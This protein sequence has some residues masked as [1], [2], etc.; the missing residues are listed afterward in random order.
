M[1]KILLIVLLLA[2][3][4]VGRLLA[5]VTLQVVSKNV[6]KT[7]PWKPGME[8]IVNGEKADVTVVPT[9][10]ATISVAAELSAKH[11]SLDTA[12]ADV[13]TWQLVVNT[14]GKKV[15]IRAYV[16]VQ[17]GKRAPVSNMRAQIKIR[18][19]RQCAV[20]LSNRFGKARLEHLDGPVALSGYFCRFDLYA[21]NGELQVESEH[22]SVDGKELKGTVDI[23]SKRADVTLQQTAGNCSLQTEYGS[24]H[25]Y[26]DT[27]SGNVRITAQM[28]DI[29]LS[30]LEANSH[31]YRLK[32]RYGNLDV[33]DKFDQSGSTE[34][35][36]SAIYQV[37]LESPSI[38]VEPS[39]G[40]I[41][42]E[43]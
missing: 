31:N 25:L 35:E 5:Q 23:K 7:V 22:G 12:Q 19:P 30:G 17:S 15:Y 40:H 16:G 18:A 36:H 33:P 24:V 27:Q 26:T 11:P 32:T 20:N 37:K 3:C 39:F 28:T 14:V 34:K 29:T 6:E 41:K 21:L 10:S 42:V 4:V 43:K 8:L 9:D 2:G 1:K 13:N 38:E